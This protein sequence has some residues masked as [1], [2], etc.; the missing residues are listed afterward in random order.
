[1]EYSDLYYN[2]AYYFDRYSIFGLSQNVTYRT[3][4]EGTIMIELKN[5]SKK[6][7]TK[8]NTFYAL[9]DINL[10]I[11]EGSFIAIMGR[12]GAGKSTLLQIIG[13]LDVF[14]KG[15]YILDNYKI[16]EMHDIQLANIRNDK[17]GF[18]FQ[19]FS[20]LNQQSVLF[21]VMLP[22]YFN[23][24]P[25]KQMKERA[26]HSLEI[27]GLLD[28][29]KKKAHQLSGGQRQRVAIARAIV[30]S[31]SIILADEPTGALDSE[32]S[33]YIMNLFQKLNEIGLTIIVVTH[34]HDVANYCSKII[35]INDGKIVKTEE[36]REV[37]IVH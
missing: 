12:S 7:G 33:K 21:N 34:D 2:C 13:C 24:T 22:M 37:S 25:Y 9:R 30:N 26:L 35:T 14:D 6:Y 11:E 29:A 16:R 8:Q 27:V 36:K 18:V 32:T 23:K 3:I 5:I 31:P 19:D 10:E 28:L 17:I 4:Q 20:L 1:M 15:E